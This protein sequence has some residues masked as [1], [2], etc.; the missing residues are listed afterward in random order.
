MHWYMVGASMHHINL[1]A[2]CAASQCTKTLVGG[3]EKLCVYHFIGTFL[4]V[5][6]K[7]GLQWH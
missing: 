3:N 4:Y 2:S 7:I 1:A 6:H 5:L